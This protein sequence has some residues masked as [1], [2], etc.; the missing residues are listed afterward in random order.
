MR[1]FS[2]L[3]VSRSGTARNASRLN[4]SAAVSLLMKYFRLDGLRF[5]LG[6]CRWAGYFL[7]QVR[8]RGGIERRNLKS[9]CPGLL[10]GWESFRAAR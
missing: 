10:R 5:P 7:N 8:L 4:G 1:T 3:T 9:H 2:T 6:A